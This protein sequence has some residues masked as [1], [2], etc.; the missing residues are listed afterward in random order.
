MDENNSTMI[1]RVNG[2][3]KAAFE[4]A[5]KRM[6]TTASQMMRAFIRDV[7]SK[8]MARNAQQSLDLPKTTRSKAK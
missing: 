8:D 5:C 7:V 1:F 2:D 4:K 6:D 3:L